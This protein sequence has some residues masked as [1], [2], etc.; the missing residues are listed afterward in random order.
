[1]PLEST[2]QAL[3]AYGFPLFWISVGVI[4]WFWPSAIFVAFSDERVT[5][6]ARAFAV[7]WL[8][9]GSALGYVFVPWASAFG[10]WVIP[11]FVLLVVG[12]L[13]LAHPVWDVSIGTYSEK[14][15]GVL[16]M[17]CGSVVLAIGLL[18]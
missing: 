14:S 9:V 13:Q 11:G 12:G 5:P 16:F 8:V 3:V 7:F 1:M 2:T 4:Q 15:G 10:G 6:G 18:S 17:A